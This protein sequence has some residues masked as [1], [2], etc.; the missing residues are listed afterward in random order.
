MTTLVKTPVAPITLIAFSK[1]HVVHTL[2][3]EEMVMAYEKA[4]EDEGSDD[5]TVAIIG[6]VVYISTVHHFINSFNACSK[7]WMSDQLRYIT[8][9]KEVTTT[10]NIM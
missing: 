10:Y 7:D 2:T 5:E 3:D 9:T 6:D 8:Y 4:N 1:S